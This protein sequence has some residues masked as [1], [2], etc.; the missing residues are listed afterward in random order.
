MSDAKTVLSVRMPVAMADAFKAEAAR[1]G[2]GVS[3][4]LLRRLAGSA[5]P[6]IERNIQA[7]ANAGTSAEG[8]QQG[9]KRLNEARVASTDRHGNVT[10]LREGK[11]DPVLTARV[12]FDQYKAET[13]LPPQY[14]DAHAHGI[15]P[16]SWFTARHG[17]PDPSH[18]DAF[19]EFLAVD[20]PSEFGLNELAWE[21]VE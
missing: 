1:L 18:I 9:I 4:L 21:F 3:E 10:A 13:Q 7:L 6:T 20:D 5:M 16:M 11:G 14:V 17:F 15:I 2:I 12:L 19:D 8:V